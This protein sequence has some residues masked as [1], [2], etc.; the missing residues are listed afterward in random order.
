M[1]Y[2]QFFSYEGLDDGQV[3]C[4]ANILDNSNHCSAVE[5]PWDNGLVKMSSKEMSSLNV[6][7]PA[8]KLHHA[9][10]PTQSVEMNEREIST[11]HT[12][13]SEE[14][15]SH[16]NFFNNQLT[17][18]Q[19]YYDHCNTFPLPPEQFNGNFHETQQL[20]NS[21]SLFKLNPT[22][23]SFVPQNMTNF[24]QSEEPINGLPTQVDSIP[25]ASKDYEDK[26]VEK[27]YIEP[28]IQNGVD[29]DTKGDK[30]EVVS[31]ENDKKCSKEPAMDEVSPPSQPVRRSWADVVSKGQKPKNTVSTKPSGSNK[32]VKNVK[33]EKENVP[34][35]VEDK[36]ASQLANHLN[37]VK[38]NFDPVLLRPRGLINRRNWCYINACI[39]ALI[40]CPPL[41]TL[42]REL[43]LG[44]GVKRGKSST[45]VIDSMVKVT[46]EFSKYDSS[47]EGLQIGSPFQPDVI[48]D[49]L[50]ELKSNC[51]KGQ[52]EDAE[53]FLSFILNGMH[54]EM[55]GISKTCEEKSN[56]KSEEIK[57]NGDVNEGE[58]E[59]QL[60]G[61]KHKG[62][63]T[64]KY[65]DFKTPIADLLGG[66][67]K[68]FIIA[69]GVRTSASI[70]P[71]FTL[72]LDIQSENVTSV[73]EAL[74]EM[75]FKI[76]VQGYTCAK[77]KQQ[78][79]AF[80]QMTF[81]K[82]PPVL[83]L[84]LKRFVYDKFGGCKKVMK[85]ADYPLV[86][87]INKDMFAS[88]IKKS[89]RAQQYKLF[90]VM[91][92]DGEEAVK[93]HY[94]SDVFN[95]GS[96]TWIRCDDRTVTAVEEEEVLSYNP[97]RVPYLLFYQ[98]S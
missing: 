5:F 21:V 56:I 22:V 4:I 66:E 53:E 86:L 8:F 19:N 60:I 84:H 88:D 29:N 93:G 59:W 54:E 35:I 52:Q 78:I 82:L 7:A 30:L 48:Y 97:P 50:R 68:T 80:T 33:M 34:S 10:L 18:P 67:R 70:E 90:A 32:V 87:D 73:S 76:P 64:T 38:L 79:E 40:A 65:A 91:Y 81:Q 39:Q 42:L 98:K 77:T 74:K 75:T 3:N 58:E 94:I 83:I 14:I 37:Q 89:Q 51:L 49:M 71:F 15:S 96:Q 61:A 6:Y 17:F 41:Y 27:D 92:H 25:S 69:N 55:V 23:S 28:V 44:P 24:P 85:K 43:P 12:T 36:M 47:Q 45:P 31:P 9:S 16:Q 13:P 72:Q 46:Y 62:M 63:V 95:H 1:D 11:F 26:I 2:F 20:P 57:E